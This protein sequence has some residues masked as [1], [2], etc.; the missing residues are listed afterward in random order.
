MGGIAVRRI[1][2]GQFDGPRPVDVQ[3]ADA[4]CAAPRGYG[5][6]H[7]LYHDSMNS[8]LRGERPAEVDSCHGRRSLAVVIAACR[9]A[10]DSLRVF[11][12]RV[13]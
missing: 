2:H 11:L 9:S 8:T 6:G 7:P 3:A 1:G 12:P 4:G 10:R 5:P 13:V